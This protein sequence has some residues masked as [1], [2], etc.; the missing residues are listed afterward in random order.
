MIMVIFL[1]ERR[2]IGPV[3]TVAFVTL[4]VIVGV[5]VLW[6]FAQKSIGRSEEIIDPDCF[7]VDLKLVKCEAYGQC[8]YYQ[9][10]SGYEADI[11]LKRGVGRANLS[12][13]RFAFED[14]I[15]RKS[16]YDFNLTG[17]QIEELQNVLFTDPWPARIPVV[18]NGPN[19][20]RAIAMIGPN[21]DVCPLTSEPVFCNTRQIAPSLGNTPGTNSAQN[22][23]CQCLPFM[24]YSTCYP[25]NDT[26]Y[27]IQ[28][29]IVYYSGTPYPWG[30][31]PGY[32][33]ICCSAT[34][35]EI[36]GRALPNY[37]GD[38][39]H[40]LNVDY[41]NNLLNYWSNSAVNP[42]GNRSYGITCPSLTGPPLISG[43]SQQ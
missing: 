43:G 30:V 2:G 18:S 42:Q 13:V 5:V 3:L 7:T 29:G 14:D 35:E 1:F 20:V 24:N 25:G 15:G 40:P 11:L 19:L 12:G 21:R 4:G 38:S 33:S 17:I 10:A 9:G 27:P 6:F 26:N 32:T 31:P 23:C 28:N 8:S 41:G 22:H 36:V 37:F 39:T 34:P 16:I